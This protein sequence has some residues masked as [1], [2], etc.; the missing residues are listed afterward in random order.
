MD[1]VKYMH[2][3]D[4]S[5]TIDFARENIYVVEPSATRAKK[6]KAGMP[7]RKYGHKELIVEGLEAEEDVAA[8]RRRVRGDAEGE[9]ASPGELA[10]SRAGKR[11]GGIDNR[12][13]AVR[14]AG[15]DQVSFP[16][17]RPTAERQVQITEYGKEPVIGKRA[18]GRN[19]YL[20]DPPR[21]KVSQRLR[22][23]E[24]DH[25]ESAPDPQDLRQLA[26]DLDIDERGINRALGAFVKQQ[27]A[28]GGKLP[29]S[30]RKR[31]KF[32]VDDRISIKG[33]TGPQ[34]RKLGQFIA[35][36]ANRVDS[37]AGVPEPLTV[38]SGRPKTRAEITK[39]TNPGNAKASLD[40]LDAILKDIPDPMASDELWSEFW[41]RMT[42]ESRTLVRPTRAFEFSNPEVVSQYITDNLSDTQRQAASEGVAVTQRFAEFYRNGQAT[43][44]DT[45]HILLWSMLSRTL[46]PYPHESGF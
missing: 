24:I 38:D 6:P 4:E 3:L 9:V 12:L 39:S 36:E 34:R 21:G 1:F 7:R 26:S 10:E 43:P 11:V 15:F 37:Y 17:V 18:V 30:L 13:R 32:N 20:R 31:N 42:G 14:A 22:D 29:S 19:D 35:Y 8:V 16:G 2:G 23:F 45:A 33:L 41:Y 27:K 46:S 25:Y 5:I 28:S 44:S 40:K